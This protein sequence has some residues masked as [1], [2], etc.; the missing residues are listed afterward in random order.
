[1]SRLARLLVSMGPVCLS[2]AALA[3]TAAP[4]PI[5]T[6]AAMP[7]ASPA[8]A[9]AAAPA[10]PPAAAP[11]RV[12]PY[13]VA[14]F[15]RTEYES[16]CYFF[17]A[18]DNT[19]ANGG[20][21]G[22]GYR[23]GIFAVEGWWSDFGKGGPTNSGQSAQMRALGVSANW[24]LRFADGFEG[25]L[26]AGLANVRYTVAGN[27]VS[28]SESHFQPTFG[29]GLAVAATPTIAVELA[30]DVTRG[31]AANE[32]TTFVNAVTLGLRLRF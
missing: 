16:L 14:A 10:V 31:D 27:G 12:G 5:A 9:P 15:G 7:E 18:C 1:M 20:K 13:V 26:R 4:A 22:L 25:L 6:P 29:L 23:S 3:Q 30:W 24:A 2:C 17:V 21:L 28:V 11:S 8:V 19:R 32:S